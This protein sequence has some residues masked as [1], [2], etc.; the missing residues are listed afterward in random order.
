MGEF[1]KDLSELINKA[2]TAA[3]SRNWAER[4]EES[5]KRAQAVYRRLF[6]RKIALAA[7]RAQAVWLSN[8]LEQARAQND[9]CQGPSKRARAQNQRAWRDHEAYR[10][11]NA[12]WNSSHKSRG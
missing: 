3:G 9:G 2:A 12:S 1:S 7:V 5:A 8:R 6:R 11:D 10:W 4:G